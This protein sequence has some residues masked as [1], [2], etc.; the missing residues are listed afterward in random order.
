MNEAGIYRHL[1]PFEA[2]YTQVPNSWLRD[3]ALSFKAKGLLA[4]LLSHEAGF[5]VSIKKL[6]RDS[7]DGV[8]AIRSAIDE[9]TQ[10]NYL[11][12]AT[13]RT[14]QGWNGGLA[15][16]LQD[17]EN[18]EFEN[19]TL[20]NPSLENQ[21]A[22][23]EN[24]LIKKTKD[25]ETIYASFE[26]FWETYPRKSGKQAALKA[27]MKAAVSSEP[28]AIVS[29]AKRYSS[30]PNIP[31]KQFIPYPATW[32]NEGRWEDEALP[33]RI[34]SKAELE[35][36]EAANRARRIEREAAQ[37]KLDAEERQRERERAEANRSVEPPKCIHGNTVARCIPCLRNFRNNE[38]NNPEGK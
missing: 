9:L 22:Y 11:K 8:H 1:L 17:P 33:E 31:P 5:T 14:A 10:N 26:I 13:T 3:P 15:W 2:N 20:E 36:E 7:G 29:G 24:N 32:L 37:R 19:P 4:Y 30:D 28:E 34:K 35:A 38:L 16:H 6:A 27:F 25:K 21:T 18:P 23:K 12:T